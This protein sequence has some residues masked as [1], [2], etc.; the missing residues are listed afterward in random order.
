MSATTRK[1][2]RKKANTRERFEDDIVFEVSPK[3]KCTKAIAQRFADKLRKGHDANVIC[4]FL[5]VNES[6]FWKW[7]K[8]GKIYLA[9]GE[10]DPTDTK[11]FPYGFFARMCARGFAEYVMRMEEKLHDANTWDYG[12]WLTIL[13]R[14]NRETWG[15]KESETGGFEEYNPD[16]RFL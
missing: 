5:G 7:I 9:S 1:R 16:E 13:E 11:N 3:S 4:A 10:W 12:R 8:L 14:R 6:T 15:R 2:K